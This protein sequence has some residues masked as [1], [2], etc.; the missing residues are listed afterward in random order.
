MLFSFVGGVLK[1]VQDTPPL[2]SASRDDVLFSMIK[3]TLTRKHLTGLQF[4]KFSSL[5]A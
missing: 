1:N 4:Q 3:A 5:A 2:F